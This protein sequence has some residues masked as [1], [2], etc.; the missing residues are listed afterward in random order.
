VPRGRKQKKQLKNGMVNINMLT[1]MDAAKVP[2]DEGQ[3][4]I[5]QTLLQLRHELNNSYGNKHVE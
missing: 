5:I 3:K 2:G 1:A 4:H